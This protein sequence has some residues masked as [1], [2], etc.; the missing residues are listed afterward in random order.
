MIGIATFTG[1]NPVRADPPL[2][3]LDTS[4]VAVIGDVLAIPVRVMEGHTRTD[5]P[6]QVELLFDD[7]IPHGALVAWIGHP[8][9]VARRP[10]MPSWT[11]PA[12]PIAII[13]PP[14]NKYERTWASGFLLCPLPAGYQGSVRLGRTIIEP[15]WLMPAPP[16][17]GEKL[18][19]KTGAGWPPIDD[20]GAW[21]RWDLL[22]E[23]QGKIPP[24]PVGSERSKLLARHIGGL[25]RAALDRLRRMSP[26][27]AAELRDLLVARCMTNTGEFISTWITSKTELKSL[28]DLMLDSG[29]DDRIV[30]R[31]ILFFLDA[32]IPVLIWTTIE[33]G[34]SIRVA[35]ANPTDEEQII[36]MQWV[37]GDPVPSAAIVPAG[38]VIEIEIDRPRQGSVAPGILQP[39]PQPNEI[40]FFVGRLQ[41]RLRLRPDRLQARPPGVQFS[42]FVAPMTLAEVW[43]GVTTAPPVHWATSAIL[44]KHD[45]RWEIFLECFFDERS[46]DGRDAVEI[47]LGPS[48]AP[49]RVIHIASDGSLRFEPG[50]GRLRGA[51]AEVRRHTDRWR[52]VVSLDPELVASATSP[53]RPGTLLIG[54]RRMLDGQSISI[55]GG[56]VPPWDPEPPVFLV[57]LM[58]WGDIKASMRSGMSQDQALL[59]SDP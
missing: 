16:L 40:I 21:W 45:E 5:V 19:A 48:G 7:G 44:R 2:K 24:D 8:T 55:A 26:G 37:D 34:A 52:A 1:V 43:S 56:V 35:I 42:P 33:T 17:S 23:K 13:D 36:R 46:P 49:V 32:R 29:R 57:D 14:S 10:A 58:T 15:E 51:R 38:R 39:R 47:H 31:S 54:L 30:V 41:H 3:V 18:T 9:S 6:E 50:G 4:P 11:S 59:Y 20:P 25:W 28:L 27:T 53:G 22:A 12:D